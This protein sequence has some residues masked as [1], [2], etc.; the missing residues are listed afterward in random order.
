MV[1][2]GIEG[3]ASTLTDLPNLT[4][5]PL[6]RVRQFATVLRDTD[7]AGRRRV[8]RVGS[9]QQSLGPHHSR[10]APDATGP[11]TNT[12]TEKGAGKKRKGNEVAN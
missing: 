10:C 12:G 7:N 11:T 9:H 8:A 1:A 6:N 2:S 3:A 5:R 4:D